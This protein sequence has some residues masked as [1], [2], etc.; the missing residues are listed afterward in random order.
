MKMQARRTLGHRDSIMIQ[1]SI[2]EM[3][4]R[5][6]VASETNRR[7]EVS[8]LK[9]LLEIKHEINRFSLANYESNLKH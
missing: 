8:A 5:S 4:F 2:K 9:Q 1:N 3:K 7:F 6:I